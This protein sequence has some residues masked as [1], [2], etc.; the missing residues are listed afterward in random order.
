[1]ASGELSS[2]ATAIGA[3]TRHE[4]QRIASGKRLNSVEFF[5]SPPVL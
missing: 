4:N 5:I 3:I 2:A 1:V